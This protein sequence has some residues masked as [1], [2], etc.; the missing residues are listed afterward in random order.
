MMAELPT[1]RSPACRMTKPKAAEMRYQEGVFRSD[2]MG[3]NWI[4]IHVDAT[5]KRDIVF[6]LS[7][8]GN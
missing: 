4:R 5:M 2:D 3:A 6:L 1:V 8:K 7:E